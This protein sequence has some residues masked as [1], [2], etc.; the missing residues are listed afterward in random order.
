MFVAKG[1][2]LVLAS[3][4]VAADSL[5]PVVPALEHGNEMENREERI[6]IVGKMANGQ[7]GR[8]PGSRDSPVAF[9]TR[10]SPTPSAVKV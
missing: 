2:R 5:F 7:A 4:G 1:K 6:M 3:D 8:V 10:K 9:A